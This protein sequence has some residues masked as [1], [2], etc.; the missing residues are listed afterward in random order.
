[1][2]KKLKNKIRKMGLRKISKTIN[3]L[4]IC[5]IAGLLLTFVMLIINEYIGTTI[6]I[7]TI[8]LFVATLYLCIIHDNIAI[9]ITEENN[10]KKLK[11]LLS[12]TKKVMYVNNSY[13]NEILL[14]KLLCYIQEMGGVEFEA[15][16]VETK[17]IVEIRIYA[18]DKI[19][20]IDLDPK[21]FL[22]NFE[23]M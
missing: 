22:K 2:L 14:E 3:K 23:V 11:E 6:E 9:E 21:T 16:Y 18:G 1:M 7:V 17:E 8:A 5:T 13:R 20:E 10:R 15:S 19:M 12:T 4:M